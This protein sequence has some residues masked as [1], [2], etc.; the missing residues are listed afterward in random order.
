MYN[1]NV[2]EGEKIT[3]V[4]HSSDQNLLST[5]REAGIKIRTGCQLIGAC[6]LCSIYVR[7]GR[8]APVTVAEKLQLGHRLAQGMRLA[9]QV[10]PESDLVIELVTHAENSEMIAHAAGILTAC[11]PSGNDAVSCPSVPTA[12]A[13]GAAVD[14]G[15]TNVSV[16]LFRSQTGERVAVRS[17]SNPQRE[18]GNDVIARMIKAS[19]D[20][21]TAEKLQQGLFGILRETLQ[22]MASS[23]GVG[24]EKITCM[25]IVGNT[26]ML[27]LFSRGSYQ[28]L[29]NP[30]YWEKT[31]SI[32]E[33]DQQKIIDFFGLGE[34][35]SVII[36]DSLA[37]FVGSDLLAGTVAIDLLDKEPGTLFVDF[38]T[39]TE[40][41][42][43]DGKTA[44]VTAAAGGPAFEGCGMSYGCSALP[45][46]I[47]QIRDT[48]ESESPFA[49][50]TID[51]KAPLGIC[52][53]GYIDLI[54]A[55]LE[56][57]LL[58]KIGRLSGQSAE[59]QEITVLR[60][61]LIKVTKKDID[62]FQRAKAAV[63]AGIRLLMHQAELSAEQIGAVFVAGNFGR[64]LD[65]PHA[66]RIGLLP[67]IDRSRVFLCGNAAVSGCAAILSDEKARDK[68]AQI[69]SMSQYINMGFDSGFE[70]LFMESLYLK[71][72]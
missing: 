20:P 19:E 50:I 72:Y 60:N 34:T 29:L 22:E 39:N 47:Y 66:Q 2:I 41:A 61:P 24:T 35:A 58:D 27:A 5:L 59:K 33:I 71:P 44:W 28:Q 14:I 18:Y 15:T 38:G 25:G 12:A 53:S 52:G 37:G 46:A 54:A 62:N 13:Y 68:L 8:T 57:G 48:G 70:S 45:G 11:K 49:V 65:I 9:C 64:F 55:L 30:E 36:I 42:L 16:M 43:W 69:R 1:I 4:I 67:T 40:I 17:F 21:A 26:A 6:A 51:N 10:I 31:L 32:P 56:R 63:A 7:S 3:R 23:V